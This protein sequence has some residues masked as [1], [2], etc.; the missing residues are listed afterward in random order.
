M[1]IRDRSKGGRVKAAVGGI[2][3]APIN[4]RRPPMSIQRE[5]EP[6]ELK[7]IQPIAKKPPQVAKPLPKDKVP[8][9]RPDQIFI[10]DVSGGRRMTGREEVELAN[11]NVSNNQI[12]PNVNISNQQTATTPEEIAALKGGGNQTEIRQV[13]KRTNFIGEKGSDQTFIGRE[14]EVRP[15]MSVKDIEDGR[16]GDERNEPKDPPNGQATIVRQ[17][18]IYA[19]NGFTYVNTNQRASTDT[20][21]DT[22]TE[23]TAEELAAQEK[24]RQQQEARQ[25]AEAAAR[26]ELP[27]GAIIPQAEQLG[28]QRDAQ[29]LSL[30]H[31]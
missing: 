30:I 5:E 26:G 9:K 6:K 16:I 18:F 3:K 21:T 13:P 10:D 11:Q 29:G 15:T 31:I 2:Q 8:L 25:S 20:D 24:T 14:G 19:W 4:R 27:E 1:C 28:Y 17:G 22:E 23:L 12:I 7:P